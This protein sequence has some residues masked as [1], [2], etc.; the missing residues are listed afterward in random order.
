MRRLRR[1]ARGQQLIEIS[2]ALLALIPIFLMLYDICVVFLVTNYNDGVARDAARAASAVE[3]V[4]V[5]TPGN[6]PLAGG[7][8]FD[9]ADRIVR[10]ARNR[11]G[12]YITNMQVDAANSRLEVSAPIPDG[13]QGGQYNG[14]VTVRTLVTFNLP[15]SFLGIVPAQQ[16]MRAEARFPLTAQ[17]TGTARTAVQ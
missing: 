7:P 3:P 13:F 4:G 10:L 15:V 5:N 14:V 2:V 9:R 6:F 16:T 17:R 12:G 11:V 1:K 8:N